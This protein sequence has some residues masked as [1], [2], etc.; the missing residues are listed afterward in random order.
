M[1]K[2]DC[3]CG[4]SI[5]KSSMN[6]HIKTKVHQRFLETGE[7]YSKPDYT[8]YHKVR[9]QNQ[10]EKLKKQSKDYYHSHPKKYHTSIKYQQYKWLYENFKDRIPEE[11]KDF[12]ITM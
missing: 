3:K 9:Y 8:N 2:I 7:K 12:K 6:K 1:I 11:L 4:K 5:T 10:K